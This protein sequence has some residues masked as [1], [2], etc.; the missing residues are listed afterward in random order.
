MLSI[1]KATL[2]AGKG[3]R[4]REG[5]FGTKWKGTQR[6][7]KWKKGGRS[8]TKKL[9]IDISV[10]CRERLVCD[11]GP[12]FPRRTRGDLSAGT[13]DGSGRERC[14]TQIWSEK[15][16]L[17][18]HGTTRELLWEQGHSSPV[19]GRRWHQ[20]PSLVHARVIPVC[21]FTA[22]QAQ[23]K[24]QGW[25]GARGQLCNDCARHCGFPVK[26]HHD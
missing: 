2:Q 14:E 20:L 10:P 1:G 4:F 3:C 21:R 26:I 17:P 16:A 12:C 22:S 23:P 7:E 25:S 19:L 15:T 13:R 24:Q 11:P 6:E 9:P 18:A 8:E 5:T